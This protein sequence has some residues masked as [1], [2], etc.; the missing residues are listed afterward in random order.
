MERSRWNRLRFTVETAGS[1]ALQRP[2]RA[3]LTALGV[4]AGTATMVTVG[5][6]TDT[7]GA[8]VDERFNLLEA[9][10]VR[11]ELS[12]GAS[13]QVTAAVD[14]AAKLN[15]VTA[16]G[17]LTEVSVSGTL[18]VTR[19]RADLGGG[20]LAPIYAVDGRAFDAVHATFRWGERPDPAATH[21]GHPVAVLG[22]RLAEQLG[23]GSAPESH[24][25]QTVF[26]A[27]VPL[28]VA[29]VIDDPGRRPEL[30]DAL[31]VSDQWAT[32]RWGATEGVT[33]VVRTQ[34]GAA[35]VVAS[36]LAVAVAPRAPG[37]VRVIPPP[38]SLSLRRHV[39]EDIRVL[40]NGLTIVVLALGAVTISNSVTVALVERR[41][42][43]AL[44]LVLGAT[45]TSIAATLL[46]EAGV[47]GAAAATVGSTL[48]VTIAAAVIAIEGWQLVLAPQVVLTAVGAGCATSVLAA[49]LPARRAT[50]VAPAD[51]LI[52]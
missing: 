15:G 23:L 12:D 10:E 45:P 14:A 39:N 47:L 36:Q 2:G 3:L 52:S 6:L 27:D 34:P 1:W 28:V 7:I 46:I 31:V 29:G 19:Q 50:R 26:V 40:A 30:T 33:L 42:E 37:Q 44:R 8:Q 16:A 4:V 48:G 49:A 35:Q 18:P 21:R 9:T 22:P 25:T 38:E 51:G 13:L 20:E 41:A 24:A 32:T 11:A 5:T 17:A 43:L